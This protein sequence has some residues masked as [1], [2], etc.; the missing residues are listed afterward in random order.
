MFKYSRLYVIP[1]STEGQKEG[2]ENGQKSVF[3]NHK[4][5]S[6]SEWVEARRD[7]L[8]KEKEFTVLRDQL[9]VYPKIIFL[10]KIIQHEN[11]T[12]PR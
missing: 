9:R 3:D 11:C 7:L 4:I 1:M 8:T 6:Q 5:V 12:N 10:Y 2:N